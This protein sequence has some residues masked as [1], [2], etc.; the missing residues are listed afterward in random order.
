MLP[1][2]WTHLF[3]AAGESNQVLIARS[4]MQIAPRLNPAAWLV[5]QQLLNEL[6]ALATVGYAF[7]G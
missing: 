6:A 4:L 5:Q 1:L 3:S 7:V 2:L